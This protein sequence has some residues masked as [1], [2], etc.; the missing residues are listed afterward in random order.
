[1]SRCSHLLLLPLLL[2]P[3]AA[4]AVPPTVLDTSPVANEL[5]VSVLAPVSVTFDTAL[6]PA[7]L[8]DGSIRVVAER[9]GWHSGTVGYSAGATTVTMTLDAPFAVGERVTVTLTPEI[10]SDLFE[11]MLAPYAWDFRVEAKPATAMFGAPAS[12][13]AYSMLQYI[14][15]GDVDGDGDQDLACMDVSSS[16]LSVLRNDGAGGFG[17]IDD[18]WL[19][20]LYGGSFADIDEDGDLDM[21]LTGHPDG[22]ITLFHNDGAGSFSD[23]VNVGTYFLGGSV[24]TADFDGDGHVDAAATGTDAE[25][26]QIFLNDGAGGMVEAWSQY[27]PYWPMSV[28]A[29]DVN[30]DGFED[31]VYVRYVQGVNVMLNNGDATFQPPVNYWNGSQGRSV[32]PGDLDG[33]GDVDLVCANWGD[34]DVS[35]FLNLGDGTFDPQQLY[36]TGS[37]PYRV[38]LADLDGDGDLDIST[39]NSVND[40]A[41][42]VENLGDGTFAPYV[43]Y[44]SGDAPRGVCA[45]D[46]DGDGALDLATAN[47]YSG[48]VA[49]LLNTRLWPPAVVATTPAPNELDVADPPA[50]TATFDRD[51]DPLTIHAGSFLVRGAVS[52][53]M[54]G[55]VDYDPGSFTADFLPDQLFATG[56][57]VTVTLTHEIADTEGAPLEGGHS[58]SFTMNAG[59]GP[60]AYPLCDSHY[61]GFAAIDVRL[62]DLDG[63]G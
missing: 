49:V 27:D 22:G 60:A 56:E 52:G 44:Y 4:S 13:G 31:L 48:D 33:D 25:L 14:L 8:H 35:V 59:P 18:Y 29:A 2:I 55:I 23:P 45:A 43:N 17:D 3:A 57:P 36:S 24:C 16:R 7:S 51:M 38:C 41:S 54:S 61:T 46:F 62:A 28:Q 11:P 15:A 12:Y 47:D 6:D 26:V 50:I 21:V 42:F 9:T 19:G 1:M 30:G 32:R 37:G 39:A 58:W 10:Q 53:P 63:D 5:A 20:G 34:D 40:G